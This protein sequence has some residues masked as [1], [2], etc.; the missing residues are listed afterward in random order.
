MKLLQSAVLL[1]FILTACKEPR[2][3]APSIPSE[4]TTHPREI[5]IMQGYPEDLLGCSCAFSR[6]REEYHQQKFIYFEKYGMTDSTQNFRVISLDGT[7]L[8]WYS[9]ENPEGFVLEIHY[10][11]ERRTDLEVREIQGRIILRF[12]NGDETVYPI[13]GY[14]GC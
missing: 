6:N 11:S 8:R 4:K 2:K 12:S 5:T 1:L 9:G 3:D 10:D 13:F 14:C 7:P